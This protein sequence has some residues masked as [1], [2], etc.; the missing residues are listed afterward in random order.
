MLI[1]YHFQNFILFNYQ[2]FKL[3]DYFDNEFKIIKIILLIIKY[4]INK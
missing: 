4:F 2:I 1:F 3:L